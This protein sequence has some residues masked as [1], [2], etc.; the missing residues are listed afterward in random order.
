MYSMTEDSMDWAGKPISLSIQCSAVL[1]VYDSY[2]DVVFTAWRTIGQTFS[3]IECLS[4]LI[5]GTFSE[6]V[7]AVS[8]LA[9]PL[10]WGCVGGLACGCVVGLPSHLCPG[11]WQDTCCNYQVHVGVKWQDSHSYIVRH[12]ELSGPCGGHQDV[13]AQHITTRR[14][15][16]RDTPVWSRNF[17]RWGLNSLAR[18]AGRGRGATGRPAPSSPP[19]R[20]PPSHFL[21]GPRRTGA[22]RR[23]SR[24]R[25]KPC[26][27]DQQCW[28]DSTHYLCPALP[29]L[30]PQHNTITNIM[31]PYFPPF[32]LHSLTHKFCQRGCSV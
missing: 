4:T 11:G 32:V 28:Q 18:V 29:G 24:W 19:A 21:T 7:S 30:L 1:Q 25:E 17:D 13:G 6:N 26:D 16:L 27:T 23:T 5:N 14:F 3:T 8:L 31:M 10:P 22:G 20:T 12:E 9:Y 15:W 2:G